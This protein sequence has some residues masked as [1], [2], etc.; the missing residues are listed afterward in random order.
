MLDHVHSSLDEL[1]E[2]M[3]EIGPP[4]LDRRPSLSGRI[5]CGAGGQHLCGMQR[6]SQMATCLPKPIDRVA[7]V[8]NDEE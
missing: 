4:Y 2:T 5:E 6:S 7:D 1:N 3:L 8:A